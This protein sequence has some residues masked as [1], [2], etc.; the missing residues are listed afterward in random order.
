MDDKDVIIERLT[1]QVQTLTER[2]ECLA[3]ENTRLRDEIA[4]LKK[5]S[6]NSSKPPSSDIVAPP[7][8][9]LRR[10]R[11]NRIGGQPGHPRHRR[12]P[13]V[14]RLSCPRRRGAS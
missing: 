6:S 8:P 14:T 11:K 10:G 3:A 5:N 7:K 9:P 1:Q 2:V 13:W 12:P 4:R